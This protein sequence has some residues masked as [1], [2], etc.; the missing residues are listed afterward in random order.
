M[1]EFCFYKHS[2]IKKR[3]GFII[4]E[5]EFMSKK[6]C[7]VHWCLIVQKTVRISNAIKIKYKK[8]KSSLISQIY[9]QNCFTKKTHL[10][11]LFYFEV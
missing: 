7:W 5:V 11:N 10:L 2:L 4:Q 3:L 9:N 1:K 6:R 8:I